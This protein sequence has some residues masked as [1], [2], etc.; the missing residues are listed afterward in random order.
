MFYTP[1]IIYILYYLDPADIRGHSG[2]F[3]NPINVIYTCI[4]TFNICVRSR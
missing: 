4:F 3:V 2:R 1:I